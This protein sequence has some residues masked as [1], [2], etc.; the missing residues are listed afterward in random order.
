MWYVLLLW[1]PFYDEENGIQKA[2]KLLR[3]E[4]LMQVYLFW[5]L[6]ISTTPYGLYFY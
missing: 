6:C 4:L 5:S 2:S 1:T 3:D